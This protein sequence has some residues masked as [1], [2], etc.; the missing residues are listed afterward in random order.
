MIRPSILLNFCLFSSLVFFPF[1]SFFF[2]F[3]SFSFSFSLSFSFSFAVGAVAGYSQHVG[4]SGHA[5]PVSAHEQPAGEPA[6]HHRQLVPLRPG[7]WPCVHAHAFIHHDRAAGLQP[8][9]AI[10]RRMEGLR[11]KEEEDEGKEKN[12]SKKTMMGK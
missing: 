3:L 2:F 6:R 8:A 9:R 7:K 5:A 12:I 11:Q 10:L 4:D 1:L